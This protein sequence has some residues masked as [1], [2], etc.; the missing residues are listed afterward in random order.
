MVS[1]CL[2]NRYRILWGNLLEIGGSSNWE[3]GEL[4]AMS[5]PLSSWT[6]A[7]DSIQFGIAN[8]VTHGSSRMHMRIPFVLPLNLSLPRLYFY[9]INW[10][11]KEWKINSQTLQVHSTGLVK[12][13]SPFL[14][15]SWPLTKIQNRTKSST[16]NLEL[17]NLFYWR[18]KA[19]KLFWI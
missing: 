9:L 17:S 4:S 6:P 19:S 13:V 5:F 10:I 7:E 18:T 16:S 1:E 14:I 11:Q 8:T 3:R 2:F 12:V 15:L